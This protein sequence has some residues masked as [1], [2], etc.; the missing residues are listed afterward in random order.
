MRQLAEYYDKSPDLI[1]EQELR[2]YFLYLKN[3][4]KAVRSAC[5]Q[6]LCGIKFF[7]EQTLLASNPFWRLA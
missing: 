2:D 7:Y 3:D 5:T 1:S 6:A 4:K